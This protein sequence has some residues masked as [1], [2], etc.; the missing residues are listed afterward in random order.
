M[1][2]VLHSALACKDTQNT[3]QDETV[4]QAMTALVNAAATAVSAR[5]R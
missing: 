3:L 2:K 5:L 1:R 4:E